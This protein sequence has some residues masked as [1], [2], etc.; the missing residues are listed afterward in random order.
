MRVRIGWN[1]GKAPMERQSVLFSMYG[2]QACVWSWLVLCFETMYQS[3]GCRDFSMTSAFFNWCWRQF[4]PHPWPCVFRVL[5][6]IL[7]VAQTT[8]PCASDP[9]LLTVFSMSSAFFNWC[10]PWLVPQP[11]PWVFRV[12]S[13]LY[14]WLKLFSI[15][16]QIQYCWLAILLVHMKCDPCS[17]LWFR[18]PQIMCTLDLC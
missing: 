5:S 4:V 3:M 1:L 8:L 2:V 11:W 17:D 14:L 16:P 18:F 6:W 7:L 13:W 12:L 15:V 9:I 10:W